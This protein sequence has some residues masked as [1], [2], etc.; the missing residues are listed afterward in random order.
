MESWCRRIKAL[1]LKM[2]LKRLPALAASLFIVFILLNKH[3]KES[4]TRIQIRRASIMQDGFDMYK[5]I[6]IKHTERRW[7]DCEENANED[8]FPVSCPFMKS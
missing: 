5:L 2:L 7:S 3:F 6:C 4:E 1:A 8:L